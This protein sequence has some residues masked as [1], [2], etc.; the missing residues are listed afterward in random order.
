M[1]LT[2]ELQK[3]IKEKLRELNGE[4]DKTTIIVETLTLLSQ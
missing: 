2:K 3:Y 1:P 4:M